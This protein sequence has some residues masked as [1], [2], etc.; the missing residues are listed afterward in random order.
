M[1][2]LNAYGK[3]DENVKYTLFAGLDF[4][5]KYLD[6]LRGKFGQIAS[7]YSNHQY[8]SRVICVKFH[9]FVTAVQKMQEEEC[10]DE[11]KV[12]DYYTLQMIQQRIQKQCCKC[13]E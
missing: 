12:V 8:G 11:Q 13:K 3:L 2:K 7:F 1:E 5:E 10:N 4:V 6:E 9:P